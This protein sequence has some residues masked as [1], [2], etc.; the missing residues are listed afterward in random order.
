MKYISSSVVFQNDVSS[1]S[2]ILWFSPSGLTSTYKKAYE[3]STANSDEYR[4][5]L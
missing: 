3:V 1:A 2:V 4:L 5:K